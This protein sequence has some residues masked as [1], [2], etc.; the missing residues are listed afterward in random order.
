M[1]PNPSTIHHVFSAVVLIPTPVGCC[2]SAAPTCPTLI[3]ETALQ[4]ARPHPSPRGS[5]LHMSVTRG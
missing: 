1:S 4:V 2:L 5:A 3:A